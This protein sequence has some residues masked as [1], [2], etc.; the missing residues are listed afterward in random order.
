[1][2]KNITLAI[3]TLTALLTAPAAPWAAASKE[4]RPAKKAPASEKPALPVD[5]DLAEILKDPKLATPFFQIAKKE[6]YCVA[7]EYRKT[8]VCIDPGP[9]NTCRSWEVR[10]VEVCVKEHCHYT[11]D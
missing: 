2:T 10:E 6:C 7:Y 9:N 4:P 8:K 5:F 1:M 11:A 3:L